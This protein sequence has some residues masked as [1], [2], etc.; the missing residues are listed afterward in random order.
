MHTSLN[1]GG[2]C[3]PCCFRY[4]VTVSLNVVDLFA[5]E[6]PHSVS[7]SCI[8]FRIGCLSSFSVRM[9]GMRV[10]FHVESPMSCSPAPALRGEPSKRN[11]VRVLQTMVTLSK[12]STA[13]TAI[14]RE[15]RMA[16]ARLPSDL[17]YWRI[18]SRRI[19]TRKANSFWRFKHAVT[20]TGVHAHGWPQ[21]LTVFAGTRRF[22]V[23]ICQFTL[24]ISLA[25]IE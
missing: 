23:P 12:N 8:S 16:C 6:F 25:Q 14:G 1:P 9:D 13:R 10:F 3:L 18:G 17:R 22:S 4:S 24:Q 21:S 20:W 2:G 15:I 11:V 5:I 19:A 7:A